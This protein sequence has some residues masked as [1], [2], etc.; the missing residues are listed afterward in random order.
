MNNEFRR[1]ASV[2][3]LITC[4]AVTGCGQDL[5]DAAIA[6]AKVLAAHSGAAQQVIW[7]D[8]AGNTT[9]VV[10]EPPAPGGTAQLVKRT[11]SNTP[12]DP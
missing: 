6:Q 2:A 12:G 4:S 5:N 9:T 8:I 7:A 3:L 1:L 11:V 10:V